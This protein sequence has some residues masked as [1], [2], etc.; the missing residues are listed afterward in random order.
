MK[1]LVL[2]LTRLLPGPLAGQILVTLGFRVVRILPP[3]G[4]P[5]EEAQPE[6]YAWLHRGKETRVVDLKKE[7]GKKQLQA[8]AKEAAIVLDSNRPGVMEK[9][10]VGPKVLRQIQPRLVYV[11]LAGY[12]DPQRHRAPGHDLTYLAAAG[13]IPRV[14]EA[15]RF[16]QLADVAGAMWAVLA[17]LVGLARGGGFFE[18]YLTDA[19]RIF[20][21]PPIPFLDGRVICYTI[22][23]TREGEIALAALESHI[24]E[25][26]CH[27]AG[28]ASWKDKAFT[29]AEDSNPFYRELCKWFQQR[30]AQ[31]WEV[32][33]EHH[34]LPIVA[35][36]PFRAQPFRLPW[37]ER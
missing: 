28:R 26:L 19:A 37:V 29:P 14:R 4:D 6:T 3:Q 31:E 35:L 16:V 25:R 33:A 18:V 27:L 7:K 17:A 36:R 30:S 2:D 32:Y 13:M 15:W 21:Y 5:L 23:P 11:R 24:W 1:P 9:L 22:Y 8:W 12:R 34:D 10:G 20:A